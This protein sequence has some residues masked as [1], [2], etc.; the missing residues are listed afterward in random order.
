MSQEKK[1]PGTAKYL[2]QLFVNCFESDYVVS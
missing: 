2:K 1:I